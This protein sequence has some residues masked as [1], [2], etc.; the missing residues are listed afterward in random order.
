MPVK[1]KALMFEYA[2]KLNEAIVAQ[3]SKTLLY[4]TWSWPKPD[5]QPVVTAAYQELAKELKAQLVPVGIAWSTMLKEHPEIGLFGNDNHHPSPVGTYLAACVFYAAL[6][7]RS[8]EGLPSTGKE[9]KDSEAGVLQKLAF[10][11]VRG[12]SGKQA[13]KTP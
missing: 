3:G 5:N 7:D 4:M 11:A 9:L 10:S 13:L 8:P 1:N 12:A 6:Y 2:R